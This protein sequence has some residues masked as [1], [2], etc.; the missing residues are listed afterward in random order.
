MRWLG[1]LWASPYTV[2]GLMLGWFLGGR[3]RVVTGVVEI[4]GPRVARFLE[5][6][7]VRAWA[8]TLGH[9]VLG[10]NPVALEESREH[11]RVHVRQFCLW[12][13]FM[14]PAY[15]L[16]SIFLLLSGKDYYRENPFEKDAYR[17]S[18]S[19]KASGR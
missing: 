12:G 1:Y 3:F 6:L 13:P 2:I 19:S 17:V 8:L 5:K 10:Q 7:P 15:L 14:G 11:E 16:S 4:E 9:V 18:E